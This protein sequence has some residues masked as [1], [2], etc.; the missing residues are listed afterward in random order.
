MLLSSH[1][2]TLLFLHLAT[3]FDEPPVTSPGE[4]PVTPPPLEVH[5]EQVIEA[6]SVINLEEGD[7]SGDELEQID[8]SRGILDH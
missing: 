2:T 1:L 8:D 7:G 4:P 5:P 6:D 3:P